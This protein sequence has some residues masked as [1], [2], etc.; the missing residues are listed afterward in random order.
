MRIT[1]L[2]LAT[3]SLLHP[4]GPISPASASMNPLEDPEPQFSVPHFSV[5]YE[6]SLITIYATDTDTNT[7]KVPHES[8]KETQKGTVKW[9]RREPPT[10]ASS[11]YWRGQIGD[12]LAH[13]FLLLDKYQRRKFVLDD[14]P[15][16]YYFYTHHVGSGGGTHDDIRQDGYIFGG[17]HKFRSTREALYHFAWLMIG[18]PAGRCKCVYDNPSKPVHR[19]QGSLNRE[20]EKNWLAFVDARRRKQYEES[21]YRSAN[22]IAYEPPS[23]TLDVFNEKCFLLDLPSSNANAQSSSMQLPTGVRPARLRSPIFSTQQPISN[24]V[25]AVSRIDSPHG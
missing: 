15:P 6:H 24:H 2:T 22:G 1:T 18:K 7:Q 9:Y 16:G 19:K 14:F 17:G 23:P 3:T 11:I 8:V 12:A 4:S 21:Q 20:L 10:S 25:G 5:D 13:K